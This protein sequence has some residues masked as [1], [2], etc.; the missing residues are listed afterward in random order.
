ML[1]LELN[2]EKGFH[3]Y[4]YD[5]NYVG[6]IV[7]NKCFDLSNVSLDERIEFDKWYDSYEGWEYNFAEEIKQ[8]C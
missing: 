5:L 1:D 8:Y 4:F 3:P 2:C 6:E 7:D